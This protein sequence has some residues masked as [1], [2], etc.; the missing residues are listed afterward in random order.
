[1][2]ESVG[3]RVYKGDKKH[4]ALLH[5]QGDAIYQVLNVDGMWGALGFRF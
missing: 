5:Y 4:M 3:L 1:M 2:R